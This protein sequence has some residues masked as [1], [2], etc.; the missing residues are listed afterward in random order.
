MELIEMKWSD[1]DWIVLPE[2]REYW[3]ALRISMF[4]DFFH[5]QE[6]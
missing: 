4:L 2:V 5:R 3:R 1:S 6:F